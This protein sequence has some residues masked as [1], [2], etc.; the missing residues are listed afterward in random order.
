MDRGC[1][2]RSEDTGQARVFDNRTTI[3]TLLL[4]S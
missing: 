1:H 3:H 4:K 2:A